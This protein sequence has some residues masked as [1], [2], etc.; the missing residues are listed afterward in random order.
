M[1][2]NWKN[3]DSQSFEVVKK[4]VLE[5][6]ILEDTLSTKD[7]SCLL[8]LSNSVAGR[9]RQVYVSRKIVEPNL[10]MIQSDTP[11]HPQS[12]DV[13]ALCTSLYHMYLKDNANP[14]AGIGFYEGIQEDIPIA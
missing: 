1:E 6:S 11:V 5:R 2:D 7:I 4:A 9:W 12:E 8:G 14:A 13:G 10:G 3:L